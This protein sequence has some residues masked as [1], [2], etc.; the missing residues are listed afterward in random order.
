[1]PS[2]LNHINE[3]SFGGI[4]NK[5]TIIYGRA[6]SNSEH[7]GRGAKI[8][9]RII[10]G[11]VAKRGEFMRLMNLFYPEDLQVKFDNNPNDQEK[12]KYAKKLAE[13]IS[14][15]GLGSEFTQ[16]L[17]TATTNYL[18]EV[19]NAHRGLG[20]ELRAEKFLNL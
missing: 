6:S 2:M 5:L 12:N 11:S 17:K 3:M 4:G 7:S 1:M 13:K 9:L 18:V 16:P 20:V 14:E 15:F 10:S 8:E 19:Q